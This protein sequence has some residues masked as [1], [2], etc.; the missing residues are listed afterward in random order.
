MK[1]RGKR[2]FNFICY[3]CIAP[4]VVLTTGGTFLACF[5]DYGGTFLCL[6]QWV[7]LSVCGWIWLL[8]AYKFLIKLFD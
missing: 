4:V 8:L 2:I 3:F 5:Y 6:G 1:E 7:L